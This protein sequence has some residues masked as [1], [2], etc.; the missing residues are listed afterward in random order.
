MLLKLHWAGGEGE[1]GGCYVL[2]FFFSPY[3][4]II[5]A[6]TYNCLLF[7]ELLHQFHTK[8]NS[9]YQAKPKSSHSSLMLKIFPHRFNKMKQ[10]TEHVKQQLLVSHCPF[11][12]AYIDLLLIKTR[13]AAKQKCTE[14][15]D[16]IFQTKTTPSLV[17]SYTTSLQI[18]LSWSTNNGSKT[19]NHFFVLLQRVWKPDKFI[20]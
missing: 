5:I 17:L 12:S 2:W 18:F 15:N 4:S 14:H 19:L 7:N 11:N 16:S 6:N 9:D 20:P 3:D 8:N 1:W 13:H 10:W